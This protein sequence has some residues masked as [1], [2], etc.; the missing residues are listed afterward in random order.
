M[1]LMY[2][3]THPASCNKGSNIIVAWA[4]EYGKYYLQAVE[5]LQVFLINDGHELGAG[6]NSLLNLLSPWDGS[7]ALQVQPVTPIQN[8]GALFLYSSRI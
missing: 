2:V 7:L 8:T 6:G 4:I 1:C 3:C 5:A